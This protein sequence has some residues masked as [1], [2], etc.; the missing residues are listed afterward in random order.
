MNTEE[1]L[2]KR[3]IYKNP[4]EIIYWDKYLHEDVQFIRNRRFYHYYNEIPYT[5]WPF[6]LRIILFYTLFYGILYFNKYSLAPIF[7]STSFIGLLYY[8]Y[9][10]FYDLIIES[11][12]F[13]KYNRKLRSVIIAGFMLFSLSEVILFGGFFWTFF[14][15]FFH[16]SSV[17]GASSI[18]LGLEVFVW[19]K[20]PLYATL[21]LLFSAIAFNGANYS[22]KW[23]SWTFAVFFS[24]F[25]IFL[26]YIF[27]I[28]QVTEYNHLVFS[29][30]DSVFGSRFY[31][32]T[33]FHGL[34]VIIG[35]IF[36]N[37]Q[38]ERLVS[39][40]FTRE[41]H[42]GY[43]LAMIYWHFVD[44]IWIF[45]FFFIYVFNNVGFQDFIII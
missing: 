31:L 34:H 42:L 40:H 25:G 39:W 11:L 37:V 23:G 22:M 13:G 1:L 28:I 14:D 16:L 21:I 35:M 18:P 20:K 30:A 15:R 36:L 17:I 3:K 45:L 7:L 26:G 32:L 29:M 9:M 43:S 5:R 8:I 12:I 41:R 10:W 27:L 2:K 44:I 6:Y 33:G 24:S 19:Y 4:K 38:H